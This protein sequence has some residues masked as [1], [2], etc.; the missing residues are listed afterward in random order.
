MPEYVPVVD[1]KITVATS[2]GRPFGP[3]VVPGSTLVGLVASQVH[4]E[5][6]RE[7]GM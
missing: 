5:K 2:P 7:K 1:G 4:I 6:L 3:S